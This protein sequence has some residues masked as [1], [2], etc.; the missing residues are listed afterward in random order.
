VNVKNQTTVRGEAFEKSDDW[1]EIG[2]KNWSTT[3]DQ[4]VDQYNYNLGRCEGLVLGLLDAL[5]ITSTTAG[6][7]KSPE[8]SR[9]RVL[10][11]QACK[12]LMD[13]KIGHTQNDSNV[14]TPEKGTPHLEQDKMFEYVSNPTLDAMSP[15]IT[16]R[17]IA[18]LIF[19]WTTVDKFNEFKRA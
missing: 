6:D 14:G 18:T 12:V 16:D 19:E 3:N 10:L 8:D 17:D 15:E 4:M 1:A 9:G 2:R 11:R 5:Y 13:E 7:S